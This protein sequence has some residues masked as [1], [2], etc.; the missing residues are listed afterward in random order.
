[1][2]RNSKSL[3]Y[4]WT[5]EL[6]E[7]HNVIM[8]MGTFQTPLDPTLEGLTHGQWQLERAKRILRTV[9]SSPEREESSLRPHKDLQSFIEYYH[10]NP[11]QRFWQALRNWSGWG[12]V[13]VSK[14]SVEGKFLD[15]ALLPVD[16][17]YWE[18]TQK[19]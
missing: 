18:E 12:Y 4:G 1:M 10:G 17:F 9:K 5:E 11:D 2:D 13:F 8:E 15:E 16:T 7:I 14:S 3:G 6:L 19:P